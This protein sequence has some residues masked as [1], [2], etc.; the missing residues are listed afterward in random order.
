M[1]VIARRSLQIA[2]YVTF[3]LVISSAPAWAQGFTASVF[4]NVIDNTGAVIPGVTITVTNTGTGQQKTVISDESGN[5]TVLQ[6]QP[7]AYSVAAELT[8][9]KQTLNQVTLAD[10]ADFE[11]EIDALPLID[12]ESV[13]VSSE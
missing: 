13:T 6:L 2:L 12:G 11:F 5:Y 7:G 4:G 8:G 9:F 10:L 3:F 1:G